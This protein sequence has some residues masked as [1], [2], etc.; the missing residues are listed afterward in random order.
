MSRCGYLIREGFRSITTHGFMSF[1]SVTVIIACLIIMGSVSLLSVNIDALIKDLEDQN[2]VVAFVEEDMTEDEAKAVEGD[3]EALDNIADAEFVS[4]SDAMDTFMTKYDESLMEGIDETVF[5]HRYVIHL[6]DISQMA[7]TEQELRNVPGIAKVN[8]HLDYAK[9]FISIRN[10]VSVVS[11][12]LIVMLVF[13]SMFIMSNTIKLASFSR[14]EEIAI[15]KMVGA[16][17]SFIRLPF[18]VEG[19]VLGIIGGGLAFFAEW[20]V[21]ELITDRLIGSMTAS[22]L[23]GGILSIVPFRSVALPVLIIYLAMGILVGA[24]GGVN[25]IKNYLKV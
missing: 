19:L 25:A 22:S 14:R 10:I 6:T 2:E 9:I 11:L 15:M 13:V 7:N 21:Y 1:A 8:A 23:T 20:G 3:I 5:R 12:V 18:V 4:R 16:N 24:V 17:N